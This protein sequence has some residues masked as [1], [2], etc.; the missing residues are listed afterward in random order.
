MKH[1]SLVCSDNKPA[2]SNLA[3]R[4]MK[5]NFPNIAADDDWLELKW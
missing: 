1:Q 4:S 3:L 5:I 2:S